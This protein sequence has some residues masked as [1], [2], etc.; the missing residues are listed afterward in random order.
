M[1]IITKQG[2][3]HVVSYP[4]F[5]TSS[6]PSLTTAQP[7]IID[8]FTSIMAVP[9]S[10]QSRGVAVNRIR[11]WSGRPRFESERDYYDS[12]AR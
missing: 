11:L 3:E 9:T 12:E 6:V 1:S 4:T 5:Y 10:Y 8:Q 2:T 7:H